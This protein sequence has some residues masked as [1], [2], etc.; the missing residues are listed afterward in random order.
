M[1]HIWRGEELVTIGV[2]AIEVGMEIVV[3]PGELVP[4]DGMVTSG[5]SSM[6]EADLTGESVPARKLVGMLVLS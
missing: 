6:S 5:S 4:V 3:K 2:E 1:A